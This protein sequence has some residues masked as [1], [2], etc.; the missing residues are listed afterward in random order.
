ME[1]TVVAAAV[2]AG[3]SIVGTDLPRVMGSIAITLT[4]YWFTHAYATMLAERMQTASK[5]AAWRETRAALFQESTVIESALPPIVLLFALW[6]ADVKADT[7]LTATLWLCVVDLFMFGW[8]GAR[9]TELGRGARLG[10]ALIAAAFGLVAVL[11]KT[12]LH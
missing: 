3:E 2:I 12:L 4:V 6:L 9:G 7:A 8:V 5:P 1:G 10:Y 11:L